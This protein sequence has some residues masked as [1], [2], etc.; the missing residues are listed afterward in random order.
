MST[1]KDF[2]GGHPLDE[3]LPGGK[4]FGEIHRVGIWEGENSLGENSPGGN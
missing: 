3:D 1:N 2:A 4:L